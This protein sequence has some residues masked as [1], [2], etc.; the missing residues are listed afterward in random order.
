MRT[1]AML[2]AV[3]GSALL[4]TCGPGPIL[5]SYEAGPI[6]YGGSRGDP[7][8]SQAP[9]SQSGGV[10][11]AQASSEN[12][13][14]TFPI[15]PGPPRR[16]AMNSRTPCVWHAKANQYE[17]CEHFSTDGRCATFGAACTEKSRPRQAIVP[18]P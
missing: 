17:V 16:Q 6:Q 14:S 10:S 7:I 4:A 18:I 5:T 15:D 12:G 11:M 2:L 8:D 13:Q 1:P 9:T 3:F